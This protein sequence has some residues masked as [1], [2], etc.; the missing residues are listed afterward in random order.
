MRLTVVRPTVA[1]A[2]PNE[3]CPLTSTA[4]GGDCRGTPS[5]GTLVPG[6]DYG[7]RTGHP[8][9]LLMTVTDAGGAGAL[10]TR[11]CAGAAGA[12]LESCGPSTAAAATAADPATTDTAACTGWARAFPAAQAASAPGMAMVVSATLRRSGGSLIVAQ[13]AAGEAGGLVSRRR[14]RRAVM[15]SWMMRAVPGSRPVARRGRRRAGGRHRAASAVCVGMHA[16]IDAALA[17]HYDDISF[18]TRARLTA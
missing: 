4:A 13:V 3:L 14:R 2:C 7:V 8:T 1:R 17:G 16:A 10:N 6:A 9:T 18:A 5:A 15:R 11:T 12:G